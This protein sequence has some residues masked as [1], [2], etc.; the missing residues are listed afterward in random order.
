MSFVFK[1][2]IPFEDIKNVI[3]NIGIKEIMEYKLFDVFMDNDKLGK[4]LKV[5]SFTFYLQSQLGTMKDKEIK[6]IMNKIIT[7]MQETFDAKLKM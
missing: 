3:N 7:I 2:D 1:K 6:S 4:D 5:Y